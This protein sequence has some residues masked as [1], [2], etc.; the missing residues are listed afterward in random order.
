MRDFKDKLESG[1]SIICAEGYIYEL[2]RRGYCQAGPFVPHVILERPDVIRAIHEE[3]AHAG[4]DVLV[5]CQYYANKHKMAQLNMVEEFEK[6]NRKALETCQDAARSSH[7]YA[8]GN[9]CNSVEYTPNDDVIIQRVRDMFREQVLWAQEVGMDLFVCETFR[10]YGEASLALDTVKEYAPGVP[11]VVTLAPYERSLTKDGL[12]YYDALERLHQEGAA[13]VGL[14]CARGPETMIDAIIDVRRSYKGPL[15]A[16][17]IPFR[18]TKTDFTWLTLHDS[19]TGKL[20]FPDDLE[21]VS[22]SNEEMKNFAKAAKFLGVSY[23]GMCCGNSPR[24]TRSLAEALNHPCPAS[25]FKSSIAGSVFAQEH[26][27]AVLKEELDE[28]S[29]PSGA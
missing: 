29:E 3:F 18:T 13:V 14:N 7:T 9:L 28:V 21:T 12:M 10:D 15:A 26:K 25:K 27:E 6:L 23:F 4:S 1:E 17:P 16:L 22:C 24:F 20:A 5:A 8:A 2:Q 11:C 19:K